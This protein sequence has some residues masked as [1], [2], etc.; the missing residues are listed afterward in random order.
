MGGTIGLGWSFVAS[1]SYEG[2]ETISKVSPLGQ[3]VESPFVSTGASRTEQ[4]DRKS[5]PLVG[6]W[7]LVS[8]S[9][10][11]EVVRAGG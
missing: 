8:R 7:I 11:G 2:D 4:S 1:V 3:R 5:R 10:R 6:W 9:M